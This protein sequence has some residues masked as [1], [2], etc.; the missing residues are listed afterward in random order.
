MVALLTHK[1]FPIYPTKNYILSCLAAIY[2]FCLLSA[3][4][5]VL[6]Y[7]KYLQKISKLSDKYQIRKPL[8]CILGM[9]THLCVARNPRNTCN[10][11]GF[12][13]AY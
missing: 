5:L 1:N 12:N 4:S 2:I 9:V 3:P 10:V 8:W 11:S 13:I 7:K 6:P